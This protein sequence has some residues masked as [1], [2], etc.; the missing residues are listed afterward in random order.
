MK[1]KTIKNLL[2]SGILVASAV[3][4]AS[5]S[6]SQNLEFLQPNQKY[7]SA[8]SIQ[9]FEVK[10]IDVFNRLRYFSGGSVARKLIEEKLYTNLEIN[11][12]SRKYV[13]KEFLNEL[14]NV[15]KDKTFE[16]HAKDI[17]LTD[18]TML[19]NI[20]KFADK[21]YLEARAEN[22]IDVVN[23]LKQSFIP[24]SSAN[25][26]VSDQ[27]LQ[28][29]YK[30]QLHQYN[31]A[32]A[33]FNTDFED[34]ESDIY[35]TESK[36]LKHFQDKMLYNYDVKYLSFKLINNQELRDTLELLNIKLSGNGTWYQI[37]DINKVIKEQ[38]LEQ[39]PYSKNLL[40]SNSLPTDK[41]LNEYQLHQFY[42]KYSLTGANDLKDPQTVEIKDTAE[43]KFAVLKTFVAIYNKL[44]NANLTV[45]DE[46]MVLD[47]GKESSL[48]ETKH[49]KDFKSDTLRDYIFKLSTEEGKKRFSNETVN[50]DGKFYLVYLISDSN[51]VDVSSYYNKDTKEFVKDESAKAKVEEIKN[52]AKEEIKKDALNDDYISKVAKKEEKDIKVYVYDQV[53][54]A[55]L[56]KELKNSNFK[57]IE[58][59]LDTNSLIKFNDSSKLEPIS[60]QEFYTYG[61]KLFGSS[62]AKQILV[63]KYVLDNYGYNKDE[64]DSKTRVNQKDL[65][66]SK[67]QLKNVLTQFSNN[68][69]EQHGYSAKDGRVEF[70]INYYNVDSYNKALKRI[71]VQKALSYYRKD[72]NK[73]VPNLFGKLKLVAEKLQQ[74]YKS[75][76]LNHLLVYIDLDMDGKMDKDLVLTEQQKTA[77]SELFQK[78]LENIKK[79][80]KPFDELK[81]FADDFNKVTRI[82][83]RSAYEKKGEG[84]SATYEIKQSLNVS[85][86]LDL[87]KAVELRKLGLNAKAEDLGSSKPT[88]NETNDPS[89]SSKFDQ[90]F[91]DHAIK[92]YNESMQ[93]KEITSQDFKLDKPV[94]ELKQQTA[95]QIKVRLDN[96]KSSFG[97][98]SLVLYKV[99]PTP[100]AKN[101]EQ[102]TDFVV[103]GNKL[104]LKNEQNTLTPEQI[105]A[106]FLNNSALLATVEFKDPLKKAL[107]T[108]AKA[109]LDKYNKNES[110]ELVVDRVLQGIVFANSQDQ[111]NYNNFIQI[112]ERK[113][114]YY[115]D[116]S[117][118]NNFTKVYSNWL[119]LL[120]N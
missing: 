74:E 23:E 40:T 119:E 102:L 63:E 71:E 12:K 75:F 87:A 57:V 79:E 90:A 26:S 29:A 45:N 51:K 82:L 72:F 17:S 19:E 92:F 50:A 7:A 113:I 1:S 62:L 49:Y 55:L 16:Q 41:E 105:N 60:L 38:Q 88:T 70:L 116:M 10:N 66:E 27:F 3:G 5:C 21:L 64:K 31:Q 48:V 4:L 58:K 18:E 91:F 54:Y 73:Q 61:N 33:K 32:M 28:K 53:V 104:N 36:I 20:N 86:N 59:G 110:Q 69:F 93:G 65:E 8:N 25:T 107:N 115:Q 80:E 34:K 30:K 6:S 99:D 11:E 76:Y 13:K 109:L 56:K 95:E 24:V 42:I 100:I 78:G 2:V 85:E 106:Y 77:I 14:A 52:L 103:N 96:L 37:P 118:E 81:K 67:T 111:V 120:K 83:P 39:Y 47:N 117:K 68:Q 108:F 46:G 35:P 15:P 84:D 94:I 101:Q 114:N 44:N 98:H 43:N 22:V 9:N 112:T 97:W 89:S